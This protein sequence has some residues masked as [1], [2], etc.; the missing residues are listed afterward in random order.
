MSFFSFRPSSEKSS[1]VFLETLDE[2]HSSEFYALAHANRDRIRPWMSWLGADFSLEAA[3]ELI[4]HSNLCKRLGEGYWL[5]IRCD[6]ALVGCAIYTALSQMERSAE[7]SYWISTPYEGKK[8]IL[9][10]CRT[11]IENA[12]FTRN[13]ETIH[14]RCAVDNKRSQTI[15]CALGFTE[16]ALQKKADLLDGEWKDIIVYT[17][18]RA[19]WAQ[20]QKLSPPL[21]EALP[22]IF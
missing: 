4:R 17:L 21:P 7:I 2:R 20:R 9:R 16:S 14:I 10:S 8:L 18:D 6:N 11:L 1:I 15:P 22:L 3:K 13:L 19:G 5:G 12:F